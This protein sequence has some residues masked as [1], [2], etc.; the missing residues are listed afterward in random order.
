[1]EKTEDKTHS[2]YVQSS[3]SEQFDQNIMEINMFA[4]LFIHQAFPNYLT[5]SL[6]RLL[7]LCLLILISH[8]E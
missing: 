5:L 7:L 1:M 8:K 3:P 2:V 4:S 6:R